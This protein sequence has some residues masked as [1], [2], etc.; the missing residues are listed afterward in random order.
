ML[1]DTQLSGGFTNIH[2][3]SDQRLEAI[4][5]KPYIIKDEDN[6]VERML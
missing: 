4:A 3:H 2:I 1:A 5:Q 6:L